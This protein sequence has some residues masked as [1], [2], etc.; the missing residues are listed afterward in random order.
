MAMTQNQAVSDIYY[1]KTLGSCRGTL[2]YLRIRRMRECA[3]MSLRMTNQC[4][5]TGL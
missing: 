4:A 5:K 1:S 3:R 2:D